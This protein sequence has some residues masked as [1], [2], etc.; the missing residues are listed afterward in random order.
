[1]LRIKFALLLGIAFKE[2]FAAK[3]KCIERADK[4]IRNLLLSTS[5]QNTPICMLRIQENV[6]LG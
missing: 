3:V 4:S 6:S 1:M 5:I 2:T